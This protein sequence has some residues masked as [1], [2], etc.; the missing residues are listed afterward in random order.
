[1]GDPATGD[2]KSPFPSKKLMEKLN[3]GVDKTLSLNLTELKLP[4]TNKKSLYDACCSLG[5]EANSP[6]LIDFKALPKRDQGALMKSIVDSLNDFRNNYSPSIHPG[7]SLSGESIRSGFK[8]SIGYDP[9][10]LPNE[11]VLY[12]NRD[13]AGPGGGVGVKFKTE[14]FQVEL[15][16]HFLPNGYQ[17]ETPGGAR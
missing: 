17:W 5:A 16:V 1:M 6:S 4:S 9:T 2:S 15:G 11:L 3:L 12:L 7:N 14:S 8:A 13:G 10:F